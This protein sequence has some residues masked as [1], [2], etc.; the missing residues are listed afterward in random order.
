MATSSR[1]VRSSQLVRDS[2]EKE[3]LAR[4]CCIPRFDASDWIRLF[5]CRFSR[6]RAAQRCTGP[7]RIRTAIHS[8]RLPTPLCGASRF[9]I[10]PLSS[11]LSASS[12]MPAADCHQLSA[13][14][15]R[16]RLAMAA[17]HENEHTF[18]CLSG[19]VVHHHTC[20]LTLA[21]CALALHLLAAAVVLDREASTWAN[22]VFSDSSSFVLSELFTVRRRM[23]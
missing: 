14:Q 17:R 4:A 6:Q 1:Q 11:P 16:Q 13:S 20:A 10:V 12:P 18:G 5:S 15:S 23:L 3:G 19:L 22:A 21:R 9:L 2:S 7:T 8:Q